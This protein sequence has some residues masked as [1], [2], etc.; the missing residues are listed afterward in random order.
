MQVDRLERFLCE[1]VAFAGG[2][3]RGGGREGLG[4]PRPNEDQTTSA[5]LQRVRTTTGVR[6]YL[7]P[8]Q[9]PSSFGLPVTKVQLQAEGIQGYI[10]PTRLPDALPDPM[11]Q[12]FESILHDTPMTITVE[13]GRNLTQILEAAYQSAREGREIA[14]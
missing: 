9:D 1:R 4:A 8:L 14:F 10:R 7:R 11:E 6:L 3:A 13:D 12:W 2:Q 5:P